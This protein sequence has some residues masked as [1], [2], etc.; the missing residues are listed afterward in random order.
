[1]AKFK[2]KPTPEVEAAQ[3]GDLIE[4]VKTDWS[5]LPS[6]V[7]DLF[8]KGNLLFGNNHIIVT[9]SGGS[10]VGDF[11]DWLVQESPNEVRPCNA[12]TFASDYEAV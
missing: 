9:T 10:V 1:M 3:I 8:E 7:A 4:I 2:K 6:W 11:T 12:S 5:L